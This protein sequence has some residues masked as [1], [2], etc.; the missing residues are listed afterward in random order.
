MKYPNII[1]FRSDK[2]SDIE[3]KYV[4]QNV[5]EKLKMLNWKGKEIMDRIGD[6]NKKDVENCRNFESFIEITKP[7]WIN[8]PG[9]KGVLFETLGDGLDKETVYGQGLHIIAPWNDIIIYDDTTQ[10]TQIDTI[11]YKDTTLQPTIY[12]NIYIREEPNHYCP[13]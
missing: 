12:E 8:I 5:T 13:W 11:C 6:I 4:P 10:S 3:K 7:L 2:Y 9:E 1:F